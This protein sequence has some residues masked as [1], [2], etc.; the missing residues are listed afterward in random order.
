VVTGEAGKR[1]F[2]EGG[3]PWPD[4]EDIPWPEEE[5]PHEAQEP[6][7]EPYTESGY[8]VRLIAAHGH[9]IRYVHGWKK[10]LV[11]DGQRWA[12][13]LD[14]QVHEWA[15]QIAR[16][17][18]IAALDAPAA[19]LTA[20]RRMEKHSA[21]TGA[22]KIAAWHR[23][24]AI[25]PAALDADPY[26]LNCLN[27]TLDLR[28]LKLRD[29]DRADLITKITRAAWKPE[30]SS[31]LWARCL[32][33][34][35]PD[36]AMRGYLGRLS[37]LCLEG[38]I[39]E[40]VLPVHL[41]D[42]AN[43][44]ST[45]FD[46]LAF[47]LGDYAGT[48]D[49]ELLLARDWAAHPTGTAALFGMRLMIVHEVDAGRRLAEA[50]IKRLTGGDEVP[51]RRMREDWW[52]FTPSHTFAWHTNHRPNVGGQDTGIWRRLRLVIWAV[53]IAEEDRDPDL[54]RKL[55]ADA[56]AILAYLVA[57]YG[58]WQYEGLAEP[59]EVI[60]ATSAWKGESDPFGRFV[61]QRCIEGPRF[62]V[63]ASALW[64]AWCDWCRAEG[65][66]AGTRTAFGLEL[67][68]RGYPEKRITGGAR[69]RLGLDLENTP[70]DQ[71]WSPGSD[72]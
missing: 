7:A 9:Q 66:E 12:L 56:D 37:G 20:A 64:A 8:A 72:G 33:T 46:A 4:A 61:A 15:W 5:P 21:I 11:W 23:Q 34:W 17:L 71:R 47:T 60:A 63:A 54:G 30:A 42:G 35:Q 62:H 48:A 3:Q 45:Y 18:T 50:T 14:D 24:V 40:H 58:A 27:G 28:T 19:V 6:A 32:E 44:K 25:T 51:A 43:G 38:Q 22:V 1:P 41:G 26:L 13:D 53:Q 55:H 59:P 69:H 29:H 49:P 31:E 10:W 36:Q 67:T 52:Y 57:G 39:S 65:E 68:R 70:S 2:T 16:A